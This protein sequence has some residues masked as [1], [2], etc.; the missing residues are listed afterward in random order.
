[1]SVLEVNQLYFKY[2]KKTILED[3]TFSLDKGDIVGLVGSSG[4]GSGFLLPSLPQM[5]LF[6]WMNQPMGWI[7]K[8]LI[9]S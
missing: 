3:V 5:N 2:G 9:I 1:M 6:F 4:R 7:L 8:G